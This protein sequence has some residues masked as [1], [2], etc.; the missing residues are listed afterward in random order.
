[1]DGRDKPGHDAVESRCKIPFTL[2]SVGFSVRLRRGSPVE[3]AQELHALG[4]GGSPAFDHCRGQH[5]SG[6][7]PAQLL[8]VRIT[9]GGPEASSR[10]S[11]D[12]VMSGLRTPWPISTP[13]RRRADTGSILSQESP[14]GTAFT[15]P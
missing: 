14:A 8:A 15:K 12:V 10:V 6:P 5:E 9:G 1:M 13:K 4:D 7:Q 2:R 11:A 3:P